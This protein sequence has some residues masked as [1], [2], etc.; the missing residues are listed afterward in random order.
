MRDN[1][2]YGVKLSGVGVFS[3]LKL[4]VVGVSSAIISL[5]TGIVLLSNGLLVDEQ[6]KAYESSFSTFIKDYPYLSILLLL[7]VISIY[8]VFSFASQYAMRKVAS[9][10]IEDKA[11]TYLEPMMDKA[12]D[13]TL[14]N[15]SEE[16]KRG[17]IQRGL[18]YSVLKLQTVNNIKEESSNR[19][20]K[21]LLAYGFSKLKLDDIPFGDEK[22][23][24]RDEIKKRVM[25]A[26]KDFATPSSQLFWAIVIYHWLVIGVILF[27]R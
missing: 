22:F 25:I 12:M 21:Y 6:G 13:K 5:I 23:N 4:A 14:G 10:V 15:I 27:M 9:R 3:F 26:I 19:W 8:F 7:T 18:D 11:E 24:V 1:I 20:V 17:M 2:K 16:E